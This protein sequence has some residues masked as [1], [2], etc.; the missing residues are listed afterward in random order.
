M[1]F[2]I[3]MSYLNTPS[4]AYRADSTASLLATVTLTL[5]SALAVHARMTRCASSLGVHALGTAQ[6]RCEGPFCLLTL[7]NAHVKQVTQT[8]C[9]ITTLSASTPTNVPSLKVRPFSVWTT[10]AGQTAQGPAAMATETTSQKDRCRVPLR[11]TWWGLRVGQL[12]T[13]VVCA[14]TTR[15]S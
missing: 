8:V 4:S 6:R 7:I 9:V 1:A 15:P 2:V 12:W 11:V 14:R 13:H 3:T 10:S 5:M